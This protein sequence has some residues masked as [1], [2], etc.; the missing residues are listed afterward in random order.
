[1]SG[2]FKKVLTAG[3]IKLFQFIKF[4]VIFNELL[5]NSDDYISHRSNNQK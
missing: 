2:L 4:N 3:K 1:M 5:I